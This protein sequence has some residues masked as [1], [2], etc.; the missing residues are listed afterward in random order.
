ML[1]NICAKIHYFRKNITFFPL[2]VIVL[3]LP[4]FAELT[5][6]KKKIVQGMV[7]DGI[8]REKTET[9]FVVVSGTQDAVFSGTE[10]TGPFISKETH[11]YPVTA[12]S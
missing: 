3:L 4:L 7:V 10:D 6:N 2:L 11:I 12:V 1:N 5:G 8:G 9:E